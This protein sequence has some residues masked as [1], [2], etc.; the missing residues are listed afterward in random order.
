MTISLSVAVIAGLLFFNT[1]FL[2]FVFT[3]AYRAFAE[4]QKLLE[5]VRL[6]IAPITHDLT[7]I[8]SDV[9]SIVRS[10]EKEMGKVGDSISAVRD[11]T[12]NIREFELMIQER[13]ERPLLDIT[14][15]LSA[16]VKGGRVFL[17]SFNKK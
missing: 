9:R 7:Q 10:A 3:R 12:Q 4:A 5:M 6:Q 2:V 16:L 8:L 17:S 1:I 11:T 13:I 15:V 14:A